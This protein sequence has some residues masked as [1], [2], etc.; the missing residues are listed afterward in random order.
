M[1][2][3]IE[4]EN[5]NAVDYDINFLNVSLTNSHKRKRKSAQTIYK[6]PI[7]TYQ[8]TPRIKGNTA[9]RVVYAFPKFSINKEKKVI[10]ELNEWGGERN[11]TLDID[12]N[13][14]N[15]PKSI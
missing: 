4:I 12:K 15:N 9:T 6:K 11:V 10:I 13:F 5:K 3:V 7:A 1:Y 8:L 14:I 2:M